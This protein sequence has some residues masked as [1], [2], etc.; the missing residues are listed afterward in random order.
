MGFKDIDLLGIEPKFTIDRKESFKTNIGSTLTILYVLLAI[1]VFVAFGRDIIEKKNPTILFTKKQNEN[2]S[3]VIDNKF[4][5]MFAIVDN[6][7]ARPLPDQE[8]M[9]NFYMT[10]INMDTKREGGLIVTNYPME[11]CRLENIPT[12][13]SKYNLTALTNYWCVGESFK[14]PMLG[15]YGGNGQF[16]RLQLDIC[17]NTT[18][19]QN[20]CFPE[21]KIYKS[22][23]V[24]N[25]HYVI[26]DTI[27]D[28]YNFYDPGARTF[29]FGYTKSNINTFSRTFFWF[30]SVIYETDENILLFS[31]R[32]QNYLQLDN[33][34][35]ELLNQERT[36]T[37]FSHVFTLMPVLDN[38]NRSYIKVQGVFAYIGGFLTT[39]KILCTFVNSYLNR[40]EVVNIFDLVVNKKLSATHQNYILR[41]NFNDS[42][43]PLSLMN[44]YLTPQNLHKSQDSKFNQPMEDVNNNFTVVSDLTRANK[45]SLR[46][47]KF[48][49]CRSITGNLCFK[50]SL[51]YFNKLEKNYEKIISIENFIKISKKTKRLENLF[52]EDHQ[53]TLLNFANVNKKKNKLTIEESINILKHKASLESTVLSNI[54]KLLLE[55]LSN[56]I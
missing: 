17:K 13:V 51:E 9:F 47:F 43:S 32:Q 29:Q 33:T 24:F 20:S 10:T 27:L 26:Q 15:T 54:D 37:F 28:G 14:Q 38:Y 30:R 6:I 50:S 1:L 42:K 45:K 34:R 49:L 11:R 25:L 44:N 52:L 35:V 4:V 48:K 31:S 7:N 3:F 22:I 39:L 2:A 53:K 41:L 16:L 5:L 36:K 18:E 40:P 8:K 56:N 46:D 55:N 23:P 12:D 19:N 21:D